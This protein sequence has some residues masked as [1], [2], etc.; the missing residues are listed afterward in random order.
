[1]TPEKM[2]TVVVHNSCFEIKRA[3]FSWLMFANTT[4]C[5]VYTRPRCSRQRSWANAWRPST[6]QEW[7]LCCVGVS[8]NRFPMECSKRMGATTLSMLF[9]GR[10]KPNE[11]EEGEEWALCPPWLPPPPS[12]SHVYYYYIHDTTH[13]QHHTHQ[14]WV[15]CT[16]LVR[17]YSYRVFLCISILVGYD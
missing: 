5:E 6:I 13:R 8:F 1:M 3:I 4:G 16:Y 15:Y 14:F 2:K 11:I 10:A 7:K 12:H 9:F 17:L